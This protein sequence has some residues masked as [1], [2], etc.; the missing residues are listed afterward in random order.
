MYEA[1]RLPLAEKQ[2]D[3]VFGVFKVSPF[4]GTPIVRRTYYSSYIA[5]TIA[6]F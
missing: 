5:W 6:T 4:R 2:N 3:I 1:T